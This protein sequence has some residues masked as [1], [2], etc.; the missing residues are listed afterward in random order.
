MT[1]RIAQ[2]IR[3]TP[4]GVIH[5]P[6]K[7]PDGAPIQSVSARSVEGTIEV[8]PQFAGGL[9]DIAEF[10]HLI[11]LYHLHMSRKFKLRVVPFLDRSEHGIFS[12]RSPSRPNPIG[13]SVVEV[14]SVK[15]RVIRARGL[16]MVDET[17]LLD[18]KPYVP[19]FDAFRTKRIGWYAGRVAKSHLRRTKADSRFVKKHAQRLI[20]ATRSKSE[21]CPSP[22]SGRR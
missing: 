5:S 1:P 6:L 15:G 14:L 13:M 17:P 2:P 4:I 9:V 11:L 21:E 22:R 19:A 16:D 10:S 8:F 7:D 3:Y 20:C 18:I 12:T